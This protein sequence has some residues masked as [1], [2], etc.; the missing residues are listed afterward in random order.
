V[1]RRPFNG[2]CLFDRYCIEDGL[3]RRLR[4]REIEEAFRLYFRHKDVRLGRV[5]A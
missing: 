2:Y 3:R 1:K 4:G 5:K